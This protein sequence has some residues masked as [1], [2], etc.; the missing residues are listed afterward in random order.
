VLMEPEEIIEELKKWNKES[1]E[2]WNN[3][4]KFANNLGYLEIY[5][6]NY[7][8]FKLK[9]LNKRDSG[10]KKEK[11]KFNAIRIYTYT[12]FENLWFGYLIAYSDFQLFTYIINQQKICYENPFFNH[13]PSF[14]AAIMHFGTCRDLFF[15]LLELCLVNLNDIDDNKIKNILKKRVNKDRFFKK[16]KDDLGYEQKDINKAKNFL[17]KNIFRNYFAH[18]LRLPWWNSPKCSKTDYYIKNDLYNKMISDDEVGVSQDIYQIFADH[19]KYESQINKADC[20]ELISGR[21]ILQ[22]THDEL[23]EFFNISLG[24]FGQY[25]K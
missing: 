5:S 16:L 9:L 24:Y 3:H 8:S 4:E 25:F 17:N 23:A 15:I 18:R 19:K 13:L 10:N 2:G 6:P 12:I 11:I 22:H 14:S 21:K 7:L 20:N 1:P